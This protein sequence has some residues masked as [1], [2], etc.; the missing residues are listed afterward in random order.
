MQGSDVLNG[1]KLRHVFPRNLDKVAASL[2]NLLPLFITLY[3]N[4]FSSSLA[5]F[6]YLLIPAR[7]M[8][9]QAYFNRFPN[10]TP[11]PQATV[12]ANFRA[13]AK[14]KRW[15]EKSKGYKNERKQYLTALADTHIGSIDRGS[16][17]EKLAGLQGLCREL[18]ISPI[19]TSITGCKKASHECSDR[20]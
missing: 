3:K 19:P 8:A 5:S 11:D 20:A 12:I 9:E 2:C 4:S 18:R 17:A 6:T 7:T 15:G 10:F 16:S 1:R 13:L 14:S